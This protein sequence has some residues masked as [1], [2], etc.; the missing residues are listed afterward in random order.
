MIILF[1]DNNKTVRLLNQDLKTIAMSL[2]KHIAR[3]L[4]AVSKQFLQPL[5]IWWHQTVASRL[6]IKGLR[7]I[8]KHK[9]MFASF[10]LSNLKYL[11]NQI[12]FI[13]LDFLLKINKTLSFRS[14]LSI[15]SIYGEDIVPTPYLKMRKYI[16]KSTLCVFPV[17]TEALPLSRLEAIAL[18]KLIV[19]SDLGLAKQIKD[20]GKDAFLIHPKAHQNYANKITELI[21][22]GALLNQF[23][24]GTR[25]NITSK[26]S[27]EIV[28]KQS[29]GFYKKTI[30]AYS[31]S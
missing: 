25:K 21:E 11:L 10:T 23:S 31:F 24:I 12:G 20:Y 28:T 26:F 2:N 5:I 6:N 19:A 4:I 13:N 18:D 17:L 7:S 8:L 16:E 29:V 9:W 14:W 15:K 3:A 27:S 22:N 30:D 1:Y